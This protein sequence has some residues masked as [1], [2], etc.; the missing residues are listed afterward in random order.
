MCGI[1]GAVFNSN[2][3]AIWKDTEALQTLLYMDALRGMDSTG[4]SMLD[5]EGGLRLVKAAMPAAAFID[6]PEWSSFRSQ[7]VS[8]GKAMIGHNRKK[9][10]GSISDDTAHPFLIDNRYAFIH[11]GTL[12]NHK[13]L[14]ETE[15]DSEALGMHLTKCE[16]D[17]QKLSEALYDVYGAYAC[18]WIDK[19][20]EMMYMLRNKERPLSYAKWDGGWAFC[21]EPGFLKLSFIRH[22][23][24]MD[25]VKEVPVHTLVSF[26]LKKYGSDP[27]LQEIPVK[28]H[29]ATT[30]IPPIQGSGRS[31]DGQSAVS[32]NQFKRISKRGLVGTA[33]KFGI[34]D[35]VEKVPGEKDCTRWHIMGESK[36]LDFPHVIH[37]E[38]KETTESDLSDFY[39]ELDWKGVI[40]SMVYDPK[41]SLVNISVK[42][43]EPVWGPVTSTV[44]Q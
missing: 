41:Q 33:I 28:K 12:Y 23:H 14:A 3:G 10:V 7:L 25:D 11:N 1:F 30:Q 4:V 35:W 13:K 5:N 34:D 31:T 21:S 24:K 19:E 37:G 2:S 18:A 40:A 42:S 32:K 29:T 17:V 16:G 9:T 36:D 44:L 27:V 6:T 15:V 8:K 20:K 38:L 43:L 22:G 39:A 26:D